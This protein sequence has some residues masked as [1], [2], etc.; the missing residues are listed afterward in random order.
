MNARTSYPQARQ[1]RRSPMPSGAARE[2]GNGRKLWAR[3]L[4]AAGCIAAFLVWYHRPMPTGLGD[5]TASAEAP[6]AVTQV[7]VA[8]SNPRQEVVIPAN[9]TPEAVVVQRMQAFSEFRRGIARDLAL[10]AGGYLSDDAERFFDAVQTGDL[11]QATALYVSIA[12]QRHGIEPNAG[13]IA[14]WPALAETF[15]VVNSVAS[16]PAS[17]LLAYGESLLSSI[18]SG[19]VYISGSSFAQSIPALL[20]DSGSRNV[21]IL[22]T[23][24]LSDPANLN[25]LAMAYPSQFQSLETA[26]IARLL[27]DE[28]NRDLDPT[29][30][31]QKV[32]TSLLEKNPDRKIAVDGSFPISGLSMATEFSGPVLTL[33]ASP[34]AAG[35]GGSPASAGSLADYWNGMA[36]RLDAESQLAAGSPMRR[37]YSDLA[38]S[39]AQLL[40]Q[41]D[42]RAEAERV[43]R[44]AVRLAPNSYEAVERLGTFLAGQGRLADATVLFDQHVVRNSDQADIVADIRARVAEI[45]LGAGPRSMN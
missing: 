19:S 9:A 16:W 22:G 21:L 8:R 5:S 35:D 15:G 24:S 42:H 20:A 30:L 36:D 2:S 45:G 13:Q 23:E 26:D 18:P 10:K 32:L 33:N 11:V 3:A 7:S 39:H 29:A 6:A 14:S 4:P 31:S 1:E 28:S 40:A 17:E 37:H 25:Y 38:L 27:G 44:L 41:Q 34:A 43:Y 12:A